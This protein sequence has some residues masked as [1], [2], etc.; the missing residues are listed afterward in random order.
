RLGESCA[1]EPR[2][3]HSLL[4]D[5]RLIAAIGRAWANEILHRPRLSPY[6]LSQDLTPA[7]VSRAAA[8]IDSEFERGLD[9]RE[10]GAGDKKTYRVHNSLG[11]PCFVC[12]PPIAR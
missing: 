12:G 1:E 8:A 2:R 7:E 4:R 11:E 3:L 5:Q 6:A 10:R 9:L